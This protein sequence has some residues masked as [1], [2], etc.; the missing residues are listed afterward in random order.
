MWRESSDVTSSR[1]Y[2]YDFTSPVL[3]HYRLCLQG[4]SHWDWAFKLWIWG[5]CSSV[6]ITFLLMSF[7]K[8]EKNLSQKPQFDLS[9]RKSLLSGKKYKIAMI[10]YPTV[11]GLKLPLSTWIPKKWVKSLGIVTVIKITCNFRKCCALK[12]SWEEGL[13]KTI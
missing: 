8:C 10:V 3:P 2:P 13:Q 7:I 6:T 4:E 12:I 11:S 1:P 5:Q 9:W